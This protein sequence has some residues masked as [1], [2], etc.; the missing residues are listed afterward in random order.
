MQELKDNEPQSKFTGSYKKKCIWEGYL[1][2]VFA[3]PTRLVWRRTAN[4]NLPMLFSMSQISC[5]SFIHH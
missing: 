2:D 3:C 5:C 1:S 4:I